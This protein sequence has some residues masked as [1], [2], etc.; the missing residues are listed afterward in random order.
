M[1]HLLSPDD[2]SYPV[3]TTFGSAPAH[4]GSTNIGAL[5]AVIRGIASIFRQ[6][7]S[8]WTRTLPWKGH[9]LESFYLAFFARLNELDSPH[10]PV[11]L[12]APRSGTP[13]PAKKGHFHAA[14]TGQSE[15]LNKL[16][17]AVHA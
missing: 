1:S 8:T 2:W 5:P 10:L 14:A 17:M 3:P 9:R 15:C 4:Q 13:E 6:K 12:G 11:D 16:L 7:A